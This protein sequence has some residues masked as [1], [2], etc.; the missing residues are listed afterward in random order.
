MSISDCYTIHKQQQRI[1]P[2]LKNIGSDYQEFFC[3]YV[4]EEF[5][6]VSLHDQTMIIP[7]RVHK[8]YIINAR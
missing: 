3:S 6:K 8:V 1:Q 7:C 5:K 4:A 2:L